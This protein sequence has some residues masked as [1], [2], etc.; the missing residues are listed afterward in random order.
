MLDPLS[1]LGLIAN[2]VQLV[3]ASA[4]ALAVCHEI[5]TLGASVEDSQMTYTTGQLEQ[6]YSALDDS[7]K[8]TAVTGSHGVRSNVV[9]RDLATQCC[10]TARALQTE[11]QSL[12]KTPGGGLRETVSKFNLKRKKGKSIEKLKGR[13]DEY[14]KVVDSKILIDLR[15]IRNSHLTSKLIITRSRQSLGVLRTQSECQDTEIEQKLLHISAR[16]ESCHIPVSQQLRADIDKVLKANEEQHVLTRQHTEAHLTAAVLDLKVSQVQLQIE[17]KKKCISQQHQEHF[18]DSLAFSEVNRRMNEV[19]ESHPETYR[20]AFDEDINH[21]RTSFAAWLKGDER[22]YWINGKAGSGKSTFMKFLATNSQTKDLLAQCYQNS[23]VLVVAFYFWLSGSLEQRSLKGLLCSVTRQLVGGEEGLLEKAIYDDEKLLTKRNIHD[24]SVGELRKLLQRLINLLVRPVCIFIDG[25]DEFDQG[26][27][28]EKL[29]SLIEEIP[30]LKRVK[31]CVSSRP[32]YYLVKRL[33]QYKHIRLQELT[34]KDIEICVHDGLQRVRMNYPLASFSEKQFD[35]MVQLMIEKADGVFLWVH[36]ALSSLLKGTR[37][38]DDPDCLED[39]IE[40]LPSEMGQLYLQMWKRLNG[41]EQRYRDEA[42]TY[43]SYAAF[44][45]HFHQVSLFELVVALDKGLQE[46]YLSSM[47]PQDPEGLKKG[48]ERLSTRLVTRCAGLL[49]LA[50]VE[51][52][53][54]TDSSANISTASSDASLQPR[55]N[56]HGSNPLTIYHKTKVKFLH[57]TARDF[58]L[59]TKDGQVLFGVPN[60]SFDSGFQNVTRARMATLVQ[61]LAEFNGTQVEKIIGDIGRSNTIHEK[62][63]L[64]TFKRLCERLSKTGSYDRHIGYRRFWESTLGIA[65][66]GIDFEGTA[67][68]CGCV[69]YVRYFVETKGPYVSP[70]YR[71]FLLLCAVR[72]LNDGNAIPIHALSMIS[73]LAAHGADLCTKQILGRRDHD[74]ALVALLSLISDTL[75]ENTRLAKQAAQT[76]QVLVPLVIGSAGRHL[77]CLRRRK[78]GWR[79]I[80]PNQYFKASETG[81]LD[82]L[83]HMSSTR[84]CFLVMRSF[85]KHSSFK[86][87]WR[88][89]VTDYQS[90]KA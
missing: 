88:Y 55:I 39:R 54:N 80:Q 61:C 43:F 23:E 17:Q 31:V 18:L 9:F 37:N 56:L 60:M 74:I 52:L 15:Y 69:D 73:W 22:V 7:L 48:C 72:G 87:L 35:R 42:A 45:F 30:Q 47:T 50:V 3:D 85:E 6:C 51:E 21:P 20:W 25:L 29:L 67:A 4:K 24:W 38:E 12:R 84:L 86:P 57:R 89:A 63:L 66:K 10:E 58:L 81:P 64:T 1:A 83:V 41:D 90:L 11:L 40:E 53:H 65:F 76:L 77:V 34:A 59:N 28:V 26:D 19:S 44:D 82:L 14:Q 49:E 8:S 36:Y 13:L 68:S 46:E 71:G 70:Y 79:L 32:E 78:K 33:S 16:L 75:L 62:E 5:Y 27:D 2:I